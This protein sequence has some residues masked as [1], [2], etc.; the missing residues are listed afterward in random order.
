MMFREPCQ[1]RQDYGSIP[2][3]ISRAA[4]A[5][6]YGSSAVKMWISLVAIRLPSMILTCFKAATLNSYLQSISRREM[7]G[8]GGCGR[9]LLER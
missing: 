3:K 4:F 8:G 2:G 5:A 1:N 7:A 9:C 6:Q